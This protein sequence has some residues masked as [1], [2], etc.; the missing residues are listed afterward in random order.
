MKNKINLNRPKISS[1]EINQRKDFN[2]VLKNSASIPA[3]PLFKKPWFLSSV[4]VATLAVVTGVYLRNK[5]DAAKSKEQVIETQ[6]IDTDSLELAQFYKAEEAKPCIAPPVEGLNIPYT[7]YKVNAEKGGDFDFKTGSKLRVPKNAFVDAQGK[8]VKGEVELRYREFHDAV[9]FF[10]SGI[11]MTYDSAGVKYQFESAGMMQLLAY[12]DGQPL[13]MAPEKEIKVELASTYKGT[14]YNLYELDTIKNN[15][16]CLGKDKV[17]NQ[18]K[19]LAVQNNLDKNTLP[20]KVEETPEFKKVENQKVNLVAEKETKIAALPKPVEPKKPSKVSKDKY[21]VNFDVDLADFPEFAVYK[22]VQWELGSE[23]KNMNNTMWVDLNKT[24]WEEASIKE[25]SKKGENYWLSLKKGSK[26]ANLLVYPV[27]EGKGYETAMK[28][29]QTKFD[30]YTVALDKRKADEKKI[31]EEHLAKL[32]ALKKQQE[33]MIAE[34]K[35]KQEEEERNM[36]TEEKVMRVFS[37]SNFG[38]YNCDNPSVYPKGVLC[39]A[40]L[41]ND[42]EIK[43]LCYNVYLVDKRKNGLFTFYKNPLNSFSF[44]PNSKNILWTVENG[45]LYYLKSES[46]ADIKNGA[47]TIKLNRLEQKFEKAEDMKTF[48]G[49]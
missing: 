40:T 23:N 3:K 29:F 9:D 10:L 14:E 2:S 43:L 30:K 6:F 24:V 13:N 32:E 35:R 26:Q 15:W 1:D 17:Q 22:G 11:P 31:E 5:D 49:I 34:W 21:T 4:V 33:A 7:V 39:H 47:R 20:K 12:K 37:V 27:F 38:V 8:P 41:A 28:E 18:S 25:G 48:F 46:F 42:K 36:G 16:S 45:V 19:T 44:D